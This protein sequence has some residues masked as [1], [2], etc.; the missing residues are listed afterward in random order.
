MD[1]LAWL[2]MAPFIS[3]SGISSRLKS[4]VV[5]KCTRT[6]NLA[7]G[8]GL[9]QVADFSIKWIYRFLSVSQTGLLT[10]EVVHGLLYLILYRNV[11]EPCFFEVGSFGVSMV[12]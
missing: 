2:E 7:I 4:N 12:R 6:D 9:K 1:R 10:G 8:F 5:S 11:F 3:R